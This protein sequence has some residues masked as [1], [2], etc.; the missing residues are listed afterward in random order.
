M[1]DNISFCDSR[2]DTSPLLK[3]ALCLMQQTVLGKDKAYPL[4]DGFLIAEGK[5]GRHPS[6]LLLFVAVLS[7]LFSGPPRC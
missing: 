6:L 3:L 2:R 5:V 4:V 1:R 7:C